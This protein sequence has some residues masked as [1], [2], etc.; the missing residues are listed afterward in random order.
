M[1]IK[2]H[3]ISFTQVYLFFKKIEEFTLSTNQEI[4]FPG[5]S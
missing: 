1:E 5:N 4:P 2:K 3:L